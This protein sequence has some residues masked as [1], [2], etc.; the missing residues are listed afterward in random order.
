MIIQSQKPS[1]VPGEVLVKL[2]PGGS[3]ENVADRYDAVVLENIE[4]PRNMAMAFGGELL[5][6][7][8]PEGVT[9]EEAI[10]EMSQD[11]QFAYAVP[12][13]IIQLG[14]QPAPPPQQPTPPPQQP[15]QQ[16]PAPPQPTPGVPNDLDSR[17]WGLSN[18][19]QD[20]GTAGVDIGALQAWKTTTGSPNGPLIAV[21]DTGVKFDHPDLAANIWTNP[22]EIA[23]DGIDNDGNGVIDDVHGFNAIDGSGNPMDDNGHG[24]HCAGTI[25]GVGNN[26]VG[27]VGVNWQ[28]Q[29][30]PIKFLNANGGG[31]L[32]DAVKAIAYANKMGARITSN[33][34]GGGGFNQALHDAIA[35][36][37]SL[38]IFAAGNSSSNNDVRP[39]YPASYE[40]DNIVSVA[41]IDR[42]GNLAD[43]SNYG[44]TSVDLAAPGKDI[45]STFINEE[46]YR[47]LSG[48]SMAT[49][50]V[51]GVAGLIATAYPEASNDEIKARLIGGATVLEGLAGKTLSGG[52]LNAPNSLENDAVPPAAPNDLLGEN[53]GTRGA[54]VRFTATGDDGWC[55]QA[56]SYK[57]VVSNEPITSQE[58]F[59]EA[60][61]LKSGAASVTGTVEDHRYD[62]LPD[63]AERKFYLGLQFRDNVGNASEVRTTE[64]TIPASRVAFQDNFDG[65]EANFTP[66]GTWGTRDVEGRGKVWS[67]SP[68]GNYEPNAD[69]SLVSRTLDLTGVK[70]PVLFFDAATDLQT[71]KDFL[72]VEVS[73]D[74][75]TWTEVA[76]LTGKTAWSTYNTSLSAYEGKEVQV[77]FHLTSDDKIERDGVMLDKVAI[78]GDPA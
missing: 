22:G 6:L 10:A 60:A 50:H 13:E 72:K 70:S 23:G 2:K 18:T 34:W 27:V 17:L 21:I 14:E 39:A 20:G 67:D 74:G 15:P 8:L 36:S 57:L 25:A 48:T 66:E 45:Y 26:G 56:S 62:L 43:F 78:L 31:T 68:E 77:R 29:I 42:N 55:G 49:P 76:Q 32:A 47:S 53:V 58:S 46:G 11:P 54:N 16:P 30:M 44:A 75:Q 24:T 71:R 7:Q 19:G 33:S 28:A 51:A 4:M 35:S 63:A 73:E 59:D 61:V 69:R 12:N 3:F 41:A 52:I 1:Y 37:N 40:I 9:T 65:Q 64:L 5:R 38:N